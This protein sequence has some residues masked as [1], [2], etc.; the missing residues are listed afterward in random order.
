MLIYT[1]FFSDFTKLV[2]GGRDGM[3]VLWDST[4]CQEVKEQEIPRNI[5]HFFMFIWIIELV[6]V[7]HKSWI[8]H[9]IFIKRGEEVHL[10]YF[11]I[12]NWLQVLFISINFLSW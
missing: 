6:L 8:V 3:V 9:E 5:V 10:K 11:G 2:S 12:E 4:R 1:L 7:Y